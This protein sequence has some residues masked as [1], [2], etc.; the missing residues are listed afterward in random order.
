[1][2]DQRIL[3]IQVGLP[4]SFG[5]DSAGDHQPWTTSFFK[6]PVAGPVWLSRTNLAGDA[7]ANQKT[8]GGP[9]KAVCC[10]PSEHYGLWE[11]RLG[12]DIPVPGAFGENFTTR[13]TLEIDACIGDVLQLG[14]AICQISQPRPP[15]WKMSRCWQ[16]PDLAA[17]VEQTGLT[18]WYLRVLQEGYIKPGAS[19]QLLERP[20]PKWPIAARTR[21]SITE[22]TVRPP[23]KRW[24]PVRCWLSPGVITCSANGQLEREPQNLNPYKLNDPPNANVPISRTPPPNQ[25]QELF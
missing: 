13:G 24:L 15:C 25:T 19:I 8:H 6:D 22:N 23:F 4:R 9:D 2:R 20:E 7:Q 14:D 11:R 10:Y 3:S 16:I 17:Q 21:S 5:G 1:M 12:R 18:G